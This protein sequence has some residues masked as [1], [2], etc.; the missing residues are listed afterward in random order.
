MKQII[1]TLSLCGLVLSATAQDIKIGPEVG[2]TVNTMWQKIGGYT[3]DTK[4]QLGFKTGGIV[5]FG[6]TEHFSVQPGLF[7]SFNH[8]TES[9]Y[10]RSYK[11]GSGT[12][13]SETDKRNY[14]ITY[15][16]LPVYAVYKTGKEFDDPH[17]W[18]GIGPSFNYGIGGRFKQDYVKYLNGV[19]SS[20]PK[21]EAIS[22]GDNQ[23]RDQVRP[24]DVW[25]NATIAYELPVGL[26]IRGWYGIGLLNV[27]PGAD[28][29]NSLRNSGGG[30]S[31]GFLFNATHRH[32]W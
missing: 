21:D 14:A 5:D 9:N 11:E 28:A 20:S 10:Q 31:V 16:Q 19:G 30:I 26:Y 12:P 32:S 25:A 29:N 2:G 18:F 3:R 1:S 27:A 22:Y 17:I 15:L 13:A 8:G 7:A 23:Y 4:Y 24:L 6:I